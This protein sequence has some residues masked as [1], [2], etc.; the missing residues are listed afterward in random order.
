MLPD[1]LPD[2][3]HLLRCVDTVL[4]TPEHNR[5]PVGV[6]SAQMNK[7][8]CRTFAVTDPDISLD[9][10]SLAKWSRW[11]RQAH[12]TRFSHDQS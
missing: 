3:N 4:L 8:L 12:V 7:A 10:S 1:S 2:A 11:R 6:V 5:V 9:G